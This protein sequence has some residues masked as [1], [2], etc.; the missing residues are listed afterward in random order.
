M[1]SIASTEPGTVRPM[2]LQDLNLVLSWRNHPDI[3]GLPLGK[4]RIARAYKAFGN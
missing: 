3:T 1:I 2:A 4:G